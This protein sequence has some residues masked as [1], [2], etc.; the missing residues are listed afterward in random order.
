MWCMCV[1]MYACVHMVC[2]HVCVCVCVC[3]WCVCACTNLLSKGEVVFT[4]EDFP[5]HPITN[6]LLVFLG[7]F[8]FVKTIHL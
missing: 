7:A 3:V 2:V 6:W 4:V 1:C 8:I 5:V